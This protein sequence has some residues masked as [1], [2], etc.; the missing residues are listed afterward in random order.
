[1]LFSHGKPTD[2]VTRCAT[3]V[4]GR[5]YLHGVRAPSLAASAAER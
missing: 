3:A 4:K 2:I 5:V 1:M